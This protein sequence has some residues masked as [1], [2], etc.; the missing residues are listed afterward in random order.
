[1][2]IVSKNEMSDAMTHTTLDDTAFVFDLF[3]VL[4]TFDAYLAR[5]EFSFVHLFD[6]SHGYQYS[7]R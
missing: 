1:M 3:S 5:L 2:I 7:F 6:R 4:R